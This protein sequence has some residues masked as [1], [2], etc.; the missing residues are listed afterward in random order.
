MA[1]GVHVHRILLVN[2]I[3]VE[4]VLTLYFVTRGGCLES[5]LVR[6]MPLRISLGSG[7]CATF[8]SLLAS[9]G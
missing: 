8:A 9:L 7:L 2:L 4:V 6:V 5:W 3:P 1:P